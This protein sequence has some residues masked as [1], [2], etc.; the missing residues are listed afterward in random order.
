MKKIYLLVASGLVFLLAVIFFAVSVIM[1]IPSERLSLLDEKLT[2]RVNSSRSALEEGAI[3]NRQDLNDFL[4]FTDSQWELSQF[5]KDEKLK[6]KKN[7]FYINESI[8]LPNLILND[9]THVNCFQHRMTFES[10]PSVFWKTLIAIEDQR[11][12]EHKGV[13]YKSIL[14]ALWYDLKSLKIVQGGSTITQQLVKNLF[15]S[16]E[17][18]ITRKIKELIMA[19]YIERNFTKEAVLESYFNEFE[20]GSLQGIKVKGLYSACLYYFKKKPSEIDLY[21]AAILIGLL[22]GPY[23]Y[24]PLKYPQRLISRTE[25]VYKKLIELGFIRS[26]MNLRWSDSKWNQWFSFLKSNEKGKTLSIFWEIKKDSILSP[27]ENFVFLKKAKELENQINNEN[28]SIKAIIGLVSNPE[29]KFSY[30]SREQRNQKIALSKERHQIGSVI[31][32]FIYK[33]LRTKFTD[34]EELFSIDPLELTLKS[35]KWSPGEAGSLTSGEVSLKKA[36]TKSLNR[37]LI[38]A[39]TDFGFDELEDQL[40]KWFENLQKPLIEYP[41]QLLGAIELS[42]DELF[43]KYVRFFNEECKYRP[44]ESNIINL[45][46]DPSQTT[47]SKMVGKYLKRHSFFGKTGTTN[48]G[49]N[50]WFIFFDGVKVGVIWVGWEASQNIKDLKL[51]GSTTAFKLFQG[52]YLNNGL[53]F[54]EIDCLQTTIP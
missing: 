6:T 13:D 17:K 45:L 33:V 52:F 39:A 36:L 28:I 44:I 2:S 19:I 9:C 41:A 23:Y 18:T 37:P 3:I 40:D 31:K 12:L 27:Y 32:P 11:F 47:I 53:R 42:V 38:R 34:L 1:E 20:W 8:E 16:N 22:K 48:K 29:K 51:Y 30:Y 24:H 43:Q 5:I 7:M 25:V 50:N 4:L 10:I 46:S 35:G 14:R 49:L 21:E 15:L 26:N 54:N